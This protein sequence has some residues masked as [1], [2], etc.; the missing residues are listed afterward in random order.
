MAVSVKGS[1]RTDFRG[2]NAPRAGED[3]PVADPEIIGFHVAAFPA[4]RRFLE[5]EESRAGVVFTE[6]EISVQE[7]A[8]RLVFGRQF[9]MIIGSSGKG[10]RFDGMEAL[11]RADGVGRGFRHI[12][13]SRFLIEFPSS[14]P[15]AHRENLRA[16]CIP[17]TDCGEIRIQKILAQIFGFGNLFAHGNGDFH[18]GAVP[19]RSGDGFGGNIRDAPRDR[20]VHARRIHG[21]EGQIGRSFGCIGIFAASCI[22]ERY[23]AGRAASE[24]Q[25]PADS[26]VCENQFISGARDGNVLKGE[27][28]IFHKNHLFEGFHLRWRAAS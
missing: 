11:R 25:H 9:V 22:R 27:N 6:K 3:F 18:V 10:D 12:G 26:A 5:K 23:G 17:H 28:D 19:E 8:V 20:L 4:R 15:V 13:P 14:R 2:M 1:V 7:F 21:D 24:I 16:D